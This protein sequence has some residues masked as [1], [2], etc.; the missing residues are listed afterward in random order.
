MA[1][2][3]RD[4][5]DNAERLVILNPLR[6]KDLSGSAVAPSLLGKNPQDE[7]RGGRRAARVMLAKM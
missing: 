2:R 7:C 1:I 6:V 3:P 4:T 5:P